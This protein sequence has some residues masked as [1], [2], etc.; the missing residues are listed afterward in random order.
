MIHS[1]HRRVFT[2]E[3]LLGPPCLVL[4]LIPFGCNSAVAEPESGLLQGAPD[5]NSVSVDGLSGSIAIGSTV[6]TTADVNF[7]TGPSTS[8]SVLRVLPEGTEL[9]TVDQKTATN[10]FY[11]VKQ[12]GSKGIGVKRT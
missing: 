10:K 1:R 12:Q 6:R 4:A 3:R 8:Y 2:A 11:A 7:R 5:D 9:T